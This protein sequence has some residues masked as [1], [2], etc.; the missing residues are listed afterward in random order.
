VPRIKVLQTSGNFYAWEST[1]WLR[2]LLDN[3]WR[4]PY[5]HIRSDDVR[6]G[7]LEDCDVL[8]VPSGGINYALRRMGRVGQ[9]AMVQWVNDGGRYV[10]YRYA[11]AQ[12][13]GVLGLTDVTLGYEPSLRDILLRVRLDARSP[14]G[15]GLGEF[16]WLV[17]DGDYLLRRNISTRP[18][19]GRFPTRSSQDFAV[20]GFPGGTRV[21]P[22]RGVITDHRVGAGRVIISSH[23]LNYR[24]ETIG[25]QRVLWNAIFGPDAGGTAHRAVYDPEAVARRAAALPD[26]SLPS[27]IVVSVPKSDATTARSV[28]RSFGV[29]VRR[30]HE[31]SGGTTFTLANPEELTLE[32]HPFAGSIPEVLRSRGVRVLGFRAPT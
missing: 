31:D 24:A 2:H 7:A 16:I 5:E 30:L 10:G 4:L 22:G 19:V 11:G 14:L 1:G 12:L 25:G 15:A 8:I 9:R 3:D 13:P 28:L 17:H 26:D 21:L 6:Q 23:D 27:A 18:V 32:E 20:N 29:P